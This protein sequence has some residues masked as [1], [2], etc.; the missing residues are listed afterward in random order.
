MDDG[1]GFSFA[2]D[3]G[4]PQR[5]PLYRVRR[6]F[7]SGRVDRFYTASVAERDEVVA[8][9]GYEP[10]GIACVVFDRSEPGSVP[11]SRLWH[12]PSRQHSFTVVPTVLRAALERGTY[13]DHGV[14]A[15][16]FGDNRRPGTVPL[17]ALVHRPTNAHLYTIDAAER[18]AALAEGYEALGISCWV[19]PAE[20]EGEGG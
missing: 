2:P 3:P 11:L 5:V 4:P 1:F 20:V 8:N 6:S 9:Q 10:E 14:V 7:R 18:D 19:F 15:Y 13:R 16:V 17:Y 12:E